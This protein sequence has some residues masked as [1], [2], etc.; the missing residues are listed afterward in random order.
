MIKGLIKILLTVVL[1]VIIVIIYLSVVGVKTDKFNNQIK[2]KILEINEKV[3]FE[4]RE[5]NYL[6]NLNNFSINITTKNSQILLEDNVIDINSIKTNVSLKSLINDQFSIDDLQISTSEIK[7]DDLILLARIVQNTPQLF[8]LN[9]IIKDGSIA[10][11]ININFDDHGKIKNDY[12]IK[13]F[14]KNTR[15]DLF[16]KSRVKDLN[17]LFDITKK[18]Y[19]LSKIYTIFNEIKFNSPFIQIKENKDLYLIDGTLLSKDQK[20]EN[21]DL[22]I[23]FG[24][25]IDSFDIKDVEFSSIN[26]F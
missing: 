26:N 9:T 19:S 10:A 23:I 25:L 18:K 21:N 14:I 24:N 20:L 17:F 4:L 13:G 1:I 7:I 15:I 12:Q 5:V 22:K 8:I 3:N 2:K 16:N 11:D 6:L